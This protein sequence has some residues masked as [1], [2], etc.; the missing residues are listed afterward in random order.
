LKKKARDAG[1]VF[2]KNADPATIT[3]EITEKLKDKG[4]VFCKETLAKL[5]AENLE[6]LREAQ[7]QPNE[8]AKWLYENQGEMRFGSENRIFLV[9]VDSENFDD[10]W[11]LKRNLDL[12]KPTIE[13]YLENFS[14]KQAEDLRVTF[15]F[16]GKPVPFTALADV[17][18][19]VK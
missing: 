6:I 9:L 16:Q 12:L 17:L 5:K 2:E 19:V 7:A 15:E 3:H 1:I 10:S 8:L 18:F 4:D 11:K 14:A 13:D